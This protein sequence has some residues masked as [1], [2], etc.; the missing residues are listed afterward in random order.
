MKSGMEMQLDELR[1]GLD[2][3]VLAGRQQNCRLQALGSTL[4][5]RRTCTLETVFGLQVHADQIS[6]S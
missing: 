4:G 1:D 3:Y 5:R 2:E 6:S